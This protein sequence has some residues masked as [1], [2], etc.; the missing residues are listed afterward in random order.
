MEK[1]RIETQRMQQFENVC[2]IYR[3][4]LEKFIYTLTRN[5]PFAMEEIYQNTMMG[6]LKGLGYLR[7][8]SKMKTWIFSIAR[9]EARRYYAYGKAAKGGCGIT[10][11]ETAGS[12]LGIDFTKWIE[13]REC[14]IALLRGLSDE[15]RQLYVLRYYYDMPLKEISGILNVNYSTIR[16]MHVRGMIKMR[17]CLKQ[18]KE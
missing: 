1:A 5:D 3:R 8:S 15:E 10:E 11:G 7:D 4:E 6:A 14:F 13:D 12:S 16:S 2:I 18:W 9:A 17:M